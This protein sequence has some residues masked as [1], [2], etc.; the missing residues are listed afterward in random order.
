MIKNSPFL[1]RYS[2]TF[3][4]I[5]FKIKSNEKNIYFDL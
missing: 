3:K 1:K 4:Y 2:L 5:E